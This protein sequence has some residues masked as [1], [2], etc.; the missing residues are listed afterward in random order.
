MTK[1]LPAFLLMAALAAPTL[2]LATPRTQSSRSSQEER[3]NAQRRVYDRTHQDY[4]VWDG[5][6]D[7]AYH[8]W[9]AERHR[10]NRDYSRLNRRDQNKYWQWRHAHPEG[11]RR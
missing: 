10:D 6:E 11:D 5:R 1:H 9:L 8:A 4:H 7:Q 2:A 3:A